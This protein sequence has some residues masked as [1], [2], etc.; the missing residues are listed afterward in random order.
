[1]PAPWEKY[2]SS[3]QPQKPWEKYGQAATNPQQPS[4][5]ADTK[6]PDIKAIGKEAA[7][8]LAAPGFAAAQAVKGIANMDTSRAGSKKRMQDL[9]TGIVDT[10]REAGQNEIQEGKQA[11][12]AVAK[13]FEP[14]L[15]PVHRAKLAG[16]GLYKAA[17]IPFEVPMKALEN[18]YGALASEGS[19]MVNDGKPLISKS[20]ATILPSLMVGGKKAP[21]VTEFS[22]AV[23]RFG[24]NFSKAKSAEDIAAEIKRATQAHADQEAASIWSRGPTTKPT[25]QVN[26]FGEGANKLYQSRKRGEAAYWTA[27]EQMGDKI[28]HDVSEQIAALKKLRETTLARADATETDVKKA[29]AAMDRAMAEL[30]APVAPEQQIIEKTREVGGRTST[31]QAQRQFPEDAGRTTRIEAEPTTTVGGKKF[32]ETSQTPITRNTTVND[33]T[34]VVT[35]S[36]YTVTTKTIKGEAPKPPRP[37]SAGDLVRAAKSLNEDTYGTADKGIMR[38][39]RNIINDPLTDL[40]KQ[41]KNFARARKLAI[42]ATQ[43]NADIY[44]TD[45]FVKSLGFDKDTL[46]EINNSQK[47]G[48]M[49][50]TDTLQRIS[51]GVDKVKT[52]ENL[53][54]AKRTLDKPTYSL[55]L[56]A[57]YAAIRSD[58]GLDPK[59]LE[60]AK[61]ML[62]EIYKEAGV[63]ASKAKQT[64]KDLE[65]ISK[66][67]QRYGI[68]ADPVVDP[69]KGGAN[70]RAIAIAKALYKASVGKPLSAGFYGTE[71]V[72]PVGKSDLELFKKAA[73]PKAQTN[74]PGAA[75]GGVISGTNKDDQK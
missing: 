34:K 59:K 33:K 22:E 38:E 54:A 63:P 64:L 23:P 70:R 14:G 15:D 69:G 1:M 52:P 4:P 56:R 29:V 45:A 6:R 74:I 28:P 50:G 65:V 8:V 47:Y 30:G 26:E 58:I 3:A 13:A 57:K 46:T 18:T 24:M 12:H 21:K 73:Q 60:A 67:A 10:L 41:N 75:I 36:P 55:F 40:G 37:S 9:G 16:Y 7:G 62:E 71:A 35:Q 66:E 68:T 27:Q 19:K 31:T 17:Q 44:K 2:Q 61:P 51:D 49:I 32:S 42:D 72:M 53:L 48:R 20:E 25:G 39:I 5:T 43:K 11:G